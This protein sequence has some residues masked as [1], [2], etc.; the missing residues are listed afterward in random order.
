VGQWVVKV[1]MPAAPFHRFESYWGSHPHCP[2][3]PQAGRRKK[4]ISP[5]LAVE[6]PK[7][8]KLGEDQQQLVLSAPVCEVAEEY[9][10]VIWQ[11]WG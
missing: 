6:T 2:H 4:I 3:G 9:S 11:F 1:Y 8:K 5:L 10:D 7:Q